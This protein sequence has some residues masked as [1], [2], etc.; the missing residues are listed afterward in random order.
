MMKHRWMRG[1]ALVLTAAMGLGLCGCS[2]TG[3][4]S[5][6]EDEERVKVVATNFALYDFA[7]TIGG[8]NVEVELLLKPGTESHTYEPAPADI[9]RVKNSDIFLYVGGESETWVTGMLQA[10]DEEKADSP[11]LD[12]AMMECV[13]ARAEEALPGIEEDEPEEEEGEEEEEYDEHIWTSPVNAQKMA[14]KIRDC[15][16][17]VDPANRSA[18]D[19][20]YDD[21]KQK[22]VEL[23][24]AFRKTVEEGKRKEIV[25]GDRFPFLYFVKEYGLTYYAAFP[26]CSSQT[27]ANAKT[28]AF[29]TGKVKEDGIPVVFHMELANESL[30]NILCEAT[31][32]QSQ[33]FY[34]CHNVTVEEY[35]EGKTYLDFM[36][37]NVESLKK[38]L[39]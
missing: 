27:E 13:E 22:L 37:E 25:F 17:R 30:C 31:G 34:A 15:Y 38:A 33:T 3:A 1:A 11:R 8:K 29:L 39:N 6:Q 14:L 2:D 18:Y 7:R 23:D 24:S 19:G 28:V 16:D 5:S 9:L 32:A 12:V 26:G 20:N 4:G 10:L 21:Y 36:Y 35:E